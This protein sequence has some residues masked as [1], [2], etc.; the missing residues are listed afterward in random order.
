MESRPFMFS[1]SNLLFNVSD[2]AFE[3]PVSAF[4]RSLL[5]RIVDWERAMKNIFIP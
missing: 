2:C 1:L 3:A 5:W 4:F